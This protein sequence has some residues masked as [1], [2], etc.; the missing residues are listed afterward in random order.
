MSAKK[1]PDH[2]TQ[3]DWDSVDSP[4]LTD[5]QL[6]AL[7]PAAEAQPGLV[8]KMIRGRGPQKAPKK[9]ATS[10]RLDADVVEHF[11]KSGRGWQ[12]RINAAL[13]KAVGL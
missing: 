3:K 9:V 1:K 12:S 13:R 7:R 11:K 5:D 6:A 10:I 2:I 8:E 4:P